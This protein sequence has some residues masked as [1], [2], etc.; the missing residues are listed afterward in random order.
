M[1]PGGDGALS[2]RFHDG[3][4][5]FSRA[6]SRGAEL[7][8]H[9][10]ASRR[11]GRRRDRRRPPR[12]ALPAPSAAAARAGCGARRTGRC[13]DEAGGGGPRRRRRPQTGPIPPRAGE[14]NRR[15]RRPRGRTDAAGGRVRR[16]PGGAAGGRAAG[17][18]AGTAAADV[19]RRGHWPRRGR[20][21]ARWSRPPQYRHARPTRRAARRRSGDRAE[22]PRLPAGARRVLVGRRARRDRRNRAGAAR[23][24]ARGRGAVTRFPMHLLA[25]A[26]CVGLAASNSWRLDATAV[27]GS[28]LAAAAVAAAESPPARLILLAVALCCCGWWWGSTRLDALDRSPMEREIGR[29]GRAIV[30]VTAPPRRGRY[31]VRA[32]GMLRSYAGRALHER[33]QLEL[34]HGRAPPQGAVL[35][36]IARVER[37][38]GPADGFDE[39]TW[40]RRHGIHVVLHADAVRSVG[41]RGGIGGVADRLRARLGVSIA[42]RLTGERRA[43]L[44]GIVLGDDEALS[45]QTRDDFRAAGLYHLLAVSGQNVVFVAGAVLAVAWVLGISRWI[46][47][48][49]AL[50]A[51]T[52]YVLAVGPQPSVVRAG[53][54]GAVA[55]LAWLTGRLRDAWYVLLLG[56]VALL[57][58]NPYLVF[59][60]GF[61]L[62]FV[63]VAAIFTLTNP[64]AARL[65]GYPLPVLIR[66]TVAVSTACGVVTAPIVWLQ[67]DALPLLAVPANAAAEPAMPALLALAF[68]TAASA[69]VWAPAA[70][71]LAWVSGWLAWYIAL[72][73]HAVG[74]LPFAQLQGATALVALVG[75]TGLA[76]YAWRRWRTPSS[77]RT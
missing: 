21:R 2:S 38:R 66:S 5:T 36:V 72:C 20:D 24:P 65:E 56:A 17:R 30:V 43:V 32:Q 60:P 16:E 49:G 15:R 75:S 54:A 34:P 3:H 77:P 73:A 42:P 69:A 51:I 1:I 27:A 58:W 64:I 18:R 10:R 19:G 68:A 44:E 31:E 76:A 57:A 61:Q 23:E 13:T 26:L 40:L 25:G 6:R 9:A 45:E 4:M 14:A 52:G 62:S 74:S 35:E 22:D 28:A 37:P 70:T 39:R 63:A 29:A 7:H 33:V 12:R 67:F 71:V 53:I 59:D 11:R 41:R 47:E 55:S 50:A 46:G 48:I 8:A